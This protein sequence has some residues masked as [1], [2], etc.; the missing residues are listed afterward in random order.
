MEGGGGGGNCFKLVF[1]E[2]VKLNCP[3]VR[4]PGLAPKNP[5]IQT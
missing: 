4:A 3:R 5:K 1:G 2:S